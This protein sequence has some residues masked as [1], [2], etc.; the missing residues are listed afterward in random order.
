MTAGLADTLHQ[1]VTNLL[2]QL[3]ALGFGQGLEVLMAVNLL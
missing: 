1:K 3:Y 2:T